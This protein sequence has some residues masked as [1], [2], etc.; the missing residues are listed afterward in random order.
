MTRGPKSG[1]NWASYVL[2]LTQIPHLARQQRMRPQAVT[3]DPLMS[4]SRRSRVDPEGKVATT[5]GV[6]YLISATVLYK[7]LSLKA[8]N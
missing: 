6:R 7:E 3:V 5:Y 4:R 2:L 1:S 8:R